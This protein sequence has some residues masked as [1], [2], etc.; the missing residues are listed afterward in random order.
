MHK[1][2]EQCNHLK[3]GRGSLLPCIS[4]PCFHKQPRQCNHIRKLWVLLCCMFSL[5]FIP[6]PCPADR[7]RRAAMSKG[8]LRYWPW[9][10]WSD[11]EWSTTGGGTREVTVSPRGQPAAVTVSPAIIIGL[12]GKAGPAVEADHRVGEPLGAGLRVRR[13]HQGSGRTK[14]RHHCLAQ[15]GYTGHGLYR[16]RDI[17]NQE[18]LTLGLISAIWLGRWGLRSA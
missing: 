4:N 11:W 7:H 2:L 12:V 10:R 9:S 17:P 5:P 3:H 14:C 18:N 15:C 16:S 6:R 8:G 1:Q 13:D